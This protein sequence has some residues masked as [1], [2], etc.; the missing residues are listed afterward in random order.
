L[1]KPKSADQLGTV[2]AA[3]H[4][5]ASILT[6]SWV[7]IALMGSEGLT[8]ATKVAILNANYIAKRLD[9][10]YPV[11]YRGATGLVAV[12]FVAVIGLTGWAFFGPMK[13]SVTTPRS[14]RSVMAPAWS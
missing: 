5:S 1:G 7:Y 10:Y 9:P 2:S 14:I 13:A 11:L 12:S 8:E 6:I 4:G 3:P